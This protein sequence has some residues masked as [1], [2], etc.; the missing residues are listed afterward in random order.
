MP[1][2]FGW[3][4]GDERNDPE[5]SEQAKVVNLSKIEIFREFLFKHVPLDPVTGKISIPENVKHVKL[6]IGLSYSA[7]M[8]QYWLSHEEDLMVFGF[9]PNPAAVMSIMNG[10]VKL[11]PYHGEPLELKYVGRDFFVV[12]CA[13]G[14]SEQN[15]ATFYITRED[16]GCSSL[17]EPEF[18]DVADIIDVPI[19][20]L[21]DFFEFFPF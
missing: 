19:F 20:S 21:S 8:S 11:Y 14:P 13:L 9:E 7:P 12:P 10:A 6:D 3:S 1:A 18:F 17:Y 16:C 5:L 15:R 4:Q 2:I